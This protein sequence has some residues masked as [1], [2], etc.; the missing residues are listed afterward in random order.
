MGRPGLAKALSVT[1]WSASTTGGS[2]SCSWA[3]TSPSTTSVWS[4]SPAVSAAAVFPS[5]CSQPCLW[6][7]W[8][9]AH[10]FAVESWRSLSAAVSVLK[11]AKRE[12]PGS[13]SVARAEMCVDAK[14]TFFHS[15]RPEAR[16]G[17]HLPNCSEDKVH[18]KETRVSAHLQDLLRAETQQLT[19]GTQRAPQLPRGS[20]V[21]ADHLVDR[22]RRAE[23]TW[24]PRPLLRPPLKQATHSRA[25]R[26]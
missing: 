13:Q 2:R 7:F 10:F 17:D 19:N 18:R 4:S 23:A 22:A 16:A 14:A 26:L 9:A 1:R 3:S 5:Q 20:K 15:R 25:S 24:L 11:R 12:E 8:L 21:S 6:S